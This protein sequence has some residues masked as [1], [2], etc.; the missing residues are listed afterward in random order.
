MTASSNRTIRFL[1]LPT[2]RNGLPA[3]LLAALAL[4]GCTPQGGGAGGN[5]SDASG[6]TGAQTA[7]NDTGPIHVGEYGSLSGDQAG[8]GQTT[9]NGIVLAIEEINAAGGVKG[10]QL[11]HFW[12]DNES[13][14][15]KVRSVVTKL[16][17]QNKVVAVLGEVAS[18]RSKTAAPVCEQYKVPMI[19][20]SST[21]PDVTVK[22]NGQVRD[23]IF[24]IC[25]IDP[26]QGEAMAKFLHDTLKFNRVAVLRNV[27]QDYSKGLADFFKKTFTTKGGTITQ[28]LSYADNDTD[29]RAQLTTIKASNPQA[30]FVPGYYNEVGLIA[31]QARE[32]GLTV[33]LAG[34]D[35]WDD[36]SVS[37]IAAVEG[38]YFTNHYS[39]SSQDPRSKTF[40]DAYTKRFGEAPNALSALGYD[41][42]K[43]LA[44]AM[45]RAQSLNGPDL[46]DAIAA[47]R[48]FKGITG[49]ITIN[50]QHNAVKP[51]VV[52]QF[53]GGKQVLVDTIQPG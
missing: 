31:Q 28:D 46:K 9:H 42:A 3:A 26:F 37:K 36:P 6:T 15:E 27:S 17:T 7:A 18:S 16:I 19:S 8:F 25:F 24:R 45:G 34:G 39:V 5:A 52:L 35:G 13:Q 11:K 21:N 12:E 32:I 44:D 41:S 38:S 1:R 50:D 20:P 53:K 49:D 4:S 10:R 43:I 2:L 47:T 23:Y 29:F 22:E 30:I 33:P 48:D 51:I 40:V 14:K